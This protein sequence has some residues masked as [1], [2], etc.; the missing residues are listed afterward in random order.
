MVEVVKKQIECKIKINSVNG[1]VSLDCETKVIF[2]VKDSEMPY[3]VSSIKEIGFVE[4]I[5]T[6]QVKNMINRIVEE[7]D[8]RIDEIKEG[9]NELE[10]SGLTIE[11]D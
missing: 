6:D 4:T 8:K 2:N 11:V 5:K 1:I 9:L 3:A 7:L 10:K